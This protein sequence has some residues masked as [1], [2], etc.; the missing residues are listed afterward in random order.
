MEIEHGGVLMD[1][2]QDRP[3]VE[4]LRSAGPGDRSALLDKL[5]TKLLTEQR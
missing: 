4:A 1:N 3:L 5:R 2:L